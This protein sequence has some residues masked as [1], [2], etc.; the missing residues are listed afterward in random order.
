M[1]PKCKYFNKCGGCSAQ[2][3][4]YSIQL[5]N[6]KKVLQQCTGFDDIEVFSDK[7]YNYR[8]RMD[9]IFTYN[10]LGFREEGK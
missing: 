6:K 10:G 1:E 8:N 5:D 2:H 7:E 3:I 4:D 9:L